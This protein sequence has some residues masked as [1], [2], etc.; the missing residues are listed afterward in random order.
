MVQGALPTR[1]FFLRYMVPWQKGAALDR[2]KEK[3]PEGEM[4]A[5]Y[6][7]YTEDEKKRLVFLLDGE[8]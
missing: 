7:M 4:Q 5:I 8:M 6:A 2:L 1:G 3:I